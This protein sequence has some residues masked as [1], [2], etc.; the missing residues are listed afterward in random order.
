MDIVVDIDHTD[1]T[2]LEIVLES[3]SGHEAWLAEEGGVDGGGGDYSYWK[4]GTVQHWGESSFG[5]WTLKVRDQGSSHSGDGALTW[6]SAYFHGVDG[7]DYDN[8]GYS[9][10]LDS[11]DDNDSISD[12]DDDC[13]TGDLGW[14]SS[15]S[16]DYDTDGCQDSGEDLDDDNDGYGDQNEIDCNSDSLDSNSTPIDTDADSVCDYVDDDDDDDGLT[17]V[18]ENDLYNTDPLD[19]DTDDDGL[20]DYEEVIQYATNPLSNDTDVDNLTDYE[21][22]LIYGTMALDPD[23]D[24][25]LLDD[26]HEAITLGTNPLLADTDFDG[27]DDYAEVIIVGSNPLSNDTDGDGLTDGAEVNF[28]SSDPLVFDPDSDSD[29]FYHFDDC[30]DSNPN[31][32]PISPEILNAID[33]DC[34][35]FIDEGFNDTD[36]DYDG[37]SDWSEYHQYGTNV[38]KPDTDGDGISDSEEID[39][40]SS[41]PLFYDSDADED[42]YYWFD[43]CNE[44]DSSISP[45]ITETLDGL[46]N[47][48][49]DQVDED[50]FWSDYDND[51]LTDYIEYYDYMTNPFDNDTDGDGILDGVELFELMSDPL[52]F[53]SDNDLDG[54]YEFQD[55]D[56]EDSGVNP[57]MEESLNGEDE[58]CDGEIDEDFYDLDSDGDGISDYSEFHNHSTNPD[59]PDTDQDGISDAVELMSDDSDPLVP[60]YDRDQDGFYEFEECDDQDGLIFPG[61]QERWNGLDDD[62]DGSIDEWVDRLGEL[63][64]NLDA[65]SMTSFYS[66]GEVY[67]GRRN[68]DALLHNWDSA[69]ETFEISLSGIQ[70]TIGAEITWLIGEYVLV[71]NG[72]QENLV[73]SLQPIDCRNT[74]NEF[75]VHLCSEGSSNQTIKAIIF[76]EEFYTEIEWEVSIPIWVE[77]DKKSEVSIGSASISVE[78]AV[79]LAVVSVIGAIGIFVGLRVFNK[80]NS[81]NEPVEVRGEDKMNEKPPSVAEVVVDDFDAFDEDF[82]EFDA[83]DD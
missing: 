62:C 51:G 38:S 47:D 35:G 14:T 39:Y 15:S 34:D 46:D 68:S 55:C 5:N 66:N 54:W 7:E 59:S 72:G 78:A 63:E 45:G 57:G 32:N 49:D 70:P 43:D 73:I 21:E 30:D 53:D 48:C 65:V 81:Q 71:T 74:A 67:D 23:T 77:P 58:D 27:L 24:N 12:A 16:T 13:S 18:N 56:E 52:T 17:D 37:L 19:N 44:N 42:G 3:P 64:T 8:D 40:Y 83:F 2:E 29:L 31:V 1:W 50:F 20:S 80:G 33:D 22:V 60:D 69:N 79:L 10:G 26:Y 6:A 25:D 36:E 28:W 75:E 4:F 82:N 41:D 76:E 9:N 61:S 11:D